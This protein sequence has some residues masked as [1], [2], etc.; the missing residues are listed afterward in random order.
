[1]PFYHELRES[2]KDKEKL[3]AILGIFKFVTI[4]FHKKGKV[5]FKEGDT[6]CTAAYVTI[7]GRVGVIRKEGT[8]S[9]NPK[10]PD[11]RSAAKD[12]NKE[13]TSANLGPGGQ[14]S[15]F[16]T[17]P[18]PK[19]YPQGFD[20]PS[21]FKQAAGRAIAQRLMHSNSSISSPLKKP[22]SSARNSGFIKALLLKQEGASPDKQLNGTF[23][24]QDG[25]TEP[26]AVGLPHYILN[27]EIYEDVEYEVKTVIPHFGK[28]IAKIPAGKIFGQVALTSNAARNAT[29]LTLDDTYLLVINKKEFELIKDFYSDEMEER[30]SFLSSAL[31]Q[32]E[33]V[34][35]IRT[36][37]KMLQ[38]FEI[39]T[40]TRVVK[41]NA[42]MLTL[43]K[44]V[45][46]GS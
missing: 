38:F 25:G 12:L 40:F 9:T 13:E 32:L 29:I 3:S 43:Q 41:T 1:M 27:D 14:I 10:Q 34:S 39:A 28:M 20:T 6:N 17:T 45:Q 18:H 19:A 11:L 21:L 23:D 36:L 4:E 8:T 31:P 37:N 24:S 33:T 26:A 16:N 2:L 46:T 30:R 42:R 15:N 44:R 7:K 5:I 22:G 35:D